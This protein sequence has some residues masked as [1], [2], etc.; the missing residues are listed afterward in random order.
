MYISASIS[1]V[2]LSVAIDFVRVELMLITLL[3][4][5]V[6]IKSLVHIS[7][8]SEIFQGNNLT[9]PDHMG[10]ICLLNIDSIPTKSFLIT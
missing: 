6:L 1:A 7:K 4:I 10:P 9:F 3:L 5:S 2:E 8:S